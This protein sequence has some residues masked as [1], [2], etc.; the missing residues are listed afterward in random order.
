MKRKR[1]TNLRLRYIAQRKILDAI[2]D[3]LATAFLEEQGTPIGAHFS[4]DRYGADKEYQ[5]TEFNLMSGTFPENIYVS[6]WAQQRLP[7][8]TLVLPTQYGFPINDVTPVGK[9]AP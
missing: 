2:G 6:V 1:S 8:G 5:I 4:S 9:K 7:D 3:Q